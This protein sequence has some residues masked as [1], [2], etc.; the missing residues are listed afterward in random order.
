LPWDAHLIEQRNALCF[1]N[2]LPSIEGVLES[3]HNAY[4][5]RVSVDKRRRF[6][7]ERNDYRSTIC[8]GEK[9]GTSY[10]KTA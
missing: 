8:Q 10:S 6:A 7:R 1:S 9:S 3:R 2:Q 4:T 5:K